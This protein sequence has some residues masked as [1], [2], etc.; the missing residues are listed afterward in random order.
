MRWLSSMVVPVALLAAVGADPLAAQSS[1]RSH[2]LRWGVQVSYDF[3]DDNLGG[4]GRLEHSLAKLMGSSS[5]DGVFEANWF[6]GTV[7]VFDLNYNLV[8]RFDSRGPEPYLGGGLSWWI[9]SGGG[10]TAT[11]L[12][13]NAL[14]GLKFQQMGRVTPVL[15]LRYVYVDGDALLVTAGLIF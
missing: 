9:L 10:S 15:Q 6:P 12:H 2:P 14:A 8:Y 3:N 11:T 4:G 13:L 1:P 5:F 7:D